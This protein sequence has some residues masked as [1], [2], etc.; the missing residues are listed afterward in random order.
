MARLKGARL[1]TVPE[2]EKGLE[3]NIALIKQLTGGDTYT[4]RF[5]NANPFEFRPEF[6]IFINT[7]HLPRTADNTVFTSSR[8]KIIP[9]ERHFEENEQDT[10]LKKLFRKEINKSA[11]LNWAVEGWRLI[12][13]TGFDA[14]PTVD[15]A[16]EA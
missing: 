2:P 5:L 7:N 16:I 9:F 10:G 3:L 11:V 4:A 12:Q 6:K 15:A 8:V 1:V 14:P 13:E